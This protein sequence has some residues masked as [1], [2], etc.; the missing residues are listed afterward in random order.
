VSGLV[1]ELERETTCDFR[2]WTVTNVVVDASEQGRQPTS[3]YKE[4]AMLGEC[5]PLIEHG[6]D[7]AHKAF[8]TI[9]E[10]RARDGI[11]AG[12]ARVDPLHM[13]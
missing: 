9:T 8:G 4:L 13:I 2:R 7:F 6:H 12:R 3:D 10:H 11:R 5:S 1:A